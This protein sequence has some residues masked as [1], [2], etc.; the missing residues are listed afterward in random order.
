MRNGENELI[1][2]AFVQAQ[3]VLKKCAHPV[4]MK[5]SGNISGKR[6]HQIW[7]R[8]SM[9]TLLG[10]S[11]IDDPKIIKALRA[12]IETLRRGQTSLGLIP[13]NVD[14]YS[15]KSNFQAYA[16]GGLWFIIGN[17]A[18]FEQT[19]DLSFLRKN[20]PAIKKIFNWYQY[21]DVDNTGLISRHEATDWQDLFPA[22]GKVF[23]VNALYYLAL[24]KG[25]IIAHYLR[26]IK[27]QK[28]Y[29][30]KARELRVQINNQF[31]FTEKKSIY[32]F[33][34][35]G[36]GTE[37]EKHDLITKG[38]DIF[39]RKVIAPKKTILKK[40][41]YYLP[42]LTYRD[43]G[44]WFDSFGHIFAILTEIIDVKRSKIILNFIEKF[45]LAK[46]YPIKSIYPPIFYNNKDWRY[47]YKFG[48]LNLPNQFHN[49]GIWPF[50]GGFY[51][52]ALVRMKQFKK[53]NDALLSL[54]KLNKKGKYS[55][56]EF[57]EWFH[58][59]SGKPMGVPHQAWSAGM[60]IYAYEA[61]KRKKVLFF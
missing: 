30:R 15:G 38:V 9:I 59:K 2:E 54:A 26:D 57:N 56:W 11:Q 47:Y 42:Y 46:P 40:N 51:V 4:G 6:Y 23:F 49:G 12:S 18:L 34:E 14:A 16:D 35:N 29:K 3:K 43:F 5:A 55:K 13:N 50:I 31:W 10:A 22:R 20:Y 21:Q 25:S 61:V 52:A 45:K 44:E 19:N 1:D 39:G 53:A 33:I 58:G 17:A 28:L 60:Y 32:Y 24:I 36:Y 37:S 48:N 8:D 7:A 41:S 27:N